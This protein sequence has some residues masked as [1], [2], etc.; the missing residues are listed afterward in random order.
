MKK[1]Q[2]LAILLVLILGLTACGK[3]EQPNKEKSDKLSVV[4]SFTI[5]S[6]MAR[7]ISGIVEYIISFQQDRPT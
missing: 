4:S 5:I 3:K 7:Q 2:L 6:D 1:K